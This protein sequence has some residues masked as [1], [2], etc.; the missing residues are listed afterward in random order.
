MFRTKSNTRTGEALKLAVALLA[1][2][3]VV[4]GGISTAAA[5]DDVKIG[6]V[7]LHQALEESEEGQRIK[8]ELEQEFQK[9]QE[10]LD[11]EQQAV[12]QKQQEMEQQAMMMT[13]EQR[14][15]KGMELQQ[16]MEKLQETYLTLQN[17]LAQQEAE[18]T[19]KLFDSMRSVIEEIGEEKDFTM[20][21]EK[22]D[23]SILYSVDGLDLTDELIERFN[24]KE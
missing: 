14:Q 18:A 16:D 2:L 17:E 11:E 6:Y 10:Q 9:R 12:M 20:I 8:S 24:A 15:Q 5:D 23:T 13:D 19:K 1:A 3:A 21:I 4:V 22:T 7:D